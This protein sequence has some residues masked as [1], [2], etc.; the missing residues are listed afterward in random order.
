M[1]AF[2]G[3]T[4]T[5]SPVFEHHGLHGLSDELHA[6]Q[7]RGDVAGMK[8][9]V[10]DPILDLYTVS[11]SWNRLAD[12]LVARYRDLA[13]NVRVTSYT[14]ADGWKDPAWREK[15]SQ[16]AHAMRAAG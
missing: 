13:P 3:S 11:S 15:W 1:I 4:R 12:A 9:L 10:T 6:L 16:V 7:Q 2:Y 8:A 14:A 5:Y